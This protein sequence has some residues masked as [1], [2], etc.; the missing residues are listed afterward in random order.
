MTKDRSTSSFKSSVFLNTT[1][2]RLGC[3][4]YLELPA[5]LSTVAI[6]IDRLS[7]RNRASGTL[8]TAKIVFRFGYHI[9]VH[10]IYSAPQDIA[11]DLTCF[12]LYSHITFSIFFEH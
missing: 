5:S 1:Y 11:I 2:V 7:Y 3:L 6:L 10:H 4:C 12:A 8:S 9:A